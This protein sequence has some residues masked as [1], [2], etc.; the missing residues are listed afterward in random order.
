MLSENSSVWF[1]WF[2]F[3]KSYIFSETSRQNKSTWNPN[4]WKLFAND[5]KQLFSIE[6]TIFTLRGFYPKFKYLSKD[7][8]RVIWPA[9]LRMLFYRCKCRFTAA[10]EEMGF[11]SV[12][13]PKEDFSVTSDSGTV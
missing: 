10:R 3:R 5:E 12:S 6:N 2:S 11:M 4:G 13:N 7:N 1:Y 9:L 8:R